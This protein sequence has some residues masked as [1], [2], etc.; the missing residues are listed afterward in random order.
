MSHNKATS[1]V[2]KAGRSTKRAA[3]AVV[4]MP[5]KVPKATPNMLAPQFGN[6]PAE[7]RVLR[8]WVAWRYGPARENGKRPKVPYNA[9]T[10]KQARV[11]DPKTWVTFDEARAA[12]D[13]GTYEGIGF[14]FTDTDPYFGLDLDGCHA[15]GCT[16]SEAM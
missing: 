3:P 7:L 8:Q 14:V 11:D 10:G 15:A 4:A 6:I 2:S 13:G 9:R 1:R 5:V 12:F 16:R